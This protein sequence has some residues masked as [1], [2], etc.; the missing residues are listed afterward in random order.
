MVSLFEVIMRNDWTDTQHN[1]A[2]CKG[3]DCE[4]KV[5][6]GRLFGKAHPFDYI[7]INDDPV[8]VNSHFDT[9]PNAG[10]FRGGPAAQAKRNAGIHEMNID[11]WHRENRKHDKPYR[12]IDF[13]VAN[14]TWLVN[15][16]DASKVA[17]MLTRHGG[18]FDKHEPRDVQ[19]CLI[20]TIIDEDYILALITK[21]AAYN[22]I[23][24][25]FHGFMMNVHEDMSDRKPICVAGYQLEPYAAIPKDIIP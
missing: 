5:F 6:W 9:C 12:A 25:Y 22:R 24:D 13:N 18:E 4:A 23:H 8:P 11:Y 17:K 19:Q 7:I 1:I 16:K 20:G 2:S 21:S 15:D 10:Q 14:I 3:E